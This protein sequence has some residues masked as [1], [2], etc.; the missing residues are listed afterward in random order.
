MASKRPFSVTLLQWL[1]LILSAWG[2]TRLIA[3][4]RWWD[5]LIEFDARP[6]PL[7]LGITGT[8]WA[9]A[10]ILLYW[11]FA[12]RKSW[13]QRA[14]LSAFFGWQ[15]ELWIERAAFQSPAQNLP[16]AVAVSCFLAGVIIVT[17]LHRSTRYYLTKSEEHEQPD[18]HP[19]PA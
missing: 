2:A 19:N 16:F 14:V 12:R 10:G 1:V 9:V 13:A 15:I 6:S 18:Q 5:V 4:L 11:S 3:A 7:Y 17:T 8:A